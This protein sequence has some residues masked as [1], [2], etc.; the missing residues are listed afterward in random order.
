MKDLRG[1]LAI[2]KAAA[3]PHSKKL[4]DIGRMLRFSAAFL[5]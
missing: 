3:P 4:V 5:L 1:A 2:R